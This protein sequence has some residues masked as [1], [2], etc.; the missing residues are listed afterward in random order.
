MTANENVGKTLS[1]LLSG[2][3]GTIHTDCCTVG[4]LFSIMV[5]TEGEK[6]RDRETERL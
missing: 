6:E 1:T 4:E 2:R 3:R 5:F